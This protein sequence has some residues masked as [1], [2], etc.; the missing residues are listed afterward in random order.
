MIVALGTLVAGFIFGYLGQ[1]SRLCFIGGIR[2]FILVRDTYLL[3]GLAAFALTAWM[4]FP[5]ARLLGGASQGAPTILDATA[6][7]LAIAGGLGVGFVSTLA[8]GCPFRQHVM[9]AQGTKSSI[10]YVVG[11]L[12]GAVIF[13]VWT[14]PLLMRLIL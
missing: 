6:L 1:R 9:A 4:A 8:N 2:D 5:L 13:H 14:A 12:A 7:L 3:K 11:F 10:V